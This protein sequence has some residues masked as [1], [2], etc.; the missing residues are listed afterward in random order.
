MKKFQ[1]FP[2]SPSPAP[3]IWIRH[4]NDGRELGNDEN[5]MKFNEVFADEI[6][7]SELHF[8]TIIYQNVFS[9]FAGV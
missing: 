3:S 6:Y 8:L 5:D 9:C 4:L 1:V 7:M 2:L